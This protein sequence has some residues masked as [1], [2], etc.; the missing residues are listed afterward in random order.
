LVVCVK[1]Y[2]QQKKVLA[3]GYKTNCKTI[4][5]LLI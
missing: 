3:L 2:S 1:T 5:I 4:K